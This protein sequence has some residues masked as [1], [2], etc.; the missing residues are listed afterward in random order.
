MN[1][2][3]GELV[4]RTIITGARVALKKPSKEKDTDETDIKIW[5]SE[6]KHFV[7]RKKSYEGAMQRTYAIGGSSAH[8]I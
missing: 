2:T 6:I 4:V 7:Y 8:K 3:K 5:K 1:L